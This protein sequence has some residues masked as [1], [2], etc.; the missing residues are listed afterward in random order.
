MRLHGLLC[1]S[2]MTLQLTVAV[3]AHEDHWSDWC[4][5]LCSVITWLSLVS[6]IFLINP[7]CYTT[8]MAFGLGSADMA[9]LTGPG[10]SQTFM[11]TSGA[12]VRCRF[13]FWAWTITLASVKGHAGARRT[14]ELSGS[15]LDAFSDGPPQLAVHIRAFHQVCISLTTAVELT[16]L[17]TYSSVKWVIF[18]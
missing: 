10:C 4:L 17:S 16:F 6:D 9:L 1:W 7:L 14:W 5:T 2:G 3:G 15:V 8:N 11:L 18:I 13:P 12:V